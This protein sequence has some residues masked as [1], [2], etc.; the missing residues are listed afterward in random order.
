MMYDPAK[1]A[2]I[3]N[4]GDARRAAYCFRNA[5]KHIRLLAGLPLSGYTKEEGPMASPHF[6][7]CAILDAAKCLGIDMGQGDAMYGSLNLS[8]KD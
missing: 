5:I 7:E 2:L 8:D 6:A 3:V 1:D 4:T